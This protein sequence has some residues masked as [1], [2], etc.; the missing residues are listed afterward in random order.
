M[1]RVDLSSEDL[2]RG[3]LENTD[4]G[5]RRAFAERSGGETVYLTRIK[6]SAVDEYP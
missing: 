1:V 4:G 2:S 3:F 6:G 5:Q